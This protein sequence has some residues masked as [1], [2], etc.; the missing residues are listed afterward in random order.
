LP[1]FEDDEDACDEDCKKKKRRKAIIAAA[2]ATGLGLTVA[3]LL[4]RKKKYGAAV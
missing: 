1:G 3:V 2:T 4:Y